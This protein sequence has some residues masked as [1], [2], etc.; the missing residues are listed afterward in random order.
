M[1]RTAGGLAVAL[2]LAGAACAHEGVSTLEAP[3]A[4]S[5]AAEGTVPVDVALEPLQ[6]VVAD[7]PTPAKS[8]AASGETGD[9]H[10][11]TSLGKLEG[12]GV[13][14]EG[15]RVVLA[16]ARMRAA[17]QVTEPALVG[18]ARL[19]PALG[20]GFLFRSSTALYTSDAFDGELRP[21][22]SFPA[23]IASVSFGPRAMLV[24]TLSGERWLVDAKTG[25]PVPMSPPGLVDVAALPDGRAAA[26]TEFGAAQVSGDHGEHWQDVTQR[27]PGPAE[28]LFVHEEAIWLTGGG[29]TARVEPGGGVSLFDK[30][31]QDKPRTL[32]PKDPRWRA[33]EPPIRRAIRLGAPLDDGSVL[34]VSDGDVVRVDPR[35]GAL[36]AVSGGRLPP[37]ATC[38]AVR[39]RDDV[40]VA[41]TRASGPAF[42]ASHL[43]AD[44]APIIE[45]TFV[46]SGTFTAGDDG[47]LAYSAPCSRTRASG[48]SPGRVVCVRGAAGSWEELDLDGVALDAGA[49]GG[50]ATGS[51]SGSG[52][53]P[54]ELR[55]VPRADGGAYGVFFTPKPGA[56]D[57][58]TGEVRMWRAD[59]LPS[60]VRTLDLRSTRFKAKDARGV[61][62]R[63]W[64]AT[65]AGT[66]RGWTD[67]GVVEVGADGAIATSAFSFDRAGLAVAGPFA[68]A[69]GKD[70]RTWQ[71]VDRGAS[72]IEVLAPFVAKPEKI[73]PP[74]VCSPVGCDLGAWYRVGWA[75]TPPSASAPPA[76]AD[77]APLV[78]VPAP[79]R[80][81]CRPVADP[82]ARSVGRTEHSP[83]DLGLGATKLPTSEG[84]SST[85]A[86]THAIEYARFA[87]ARPAVVPARSAETAPD[88]D[89]AAPRA[90]V[91]GYAVDN[92]G[93]RITV[94]GPNRDAM[95]LRR[96]I[97]FVA[98]FDPS[99]AVRR[100]VFGVPEIVASA[101]A[102][103]LGTGDVIAEDP[104]AIS[105]FA[106]V[107]PQD[108]AA[109]SD[110]VFAGA[111]GLVGSARALAGGGARARV[112]MRL[113]ST[114]EVYPV[115]GVSLGGDEIALLLVDTDGQGHVVKWAGGAGVTGVFDVPAP[116]AADL[117][118]A[119]PDALALGAK[120]GELAVVRT[121]SG[122]APP[123]AGDPALVFAPM[124][125]GQAGAQVAVLAP[126]TPST[127]LA[128]GDAACRSDP[129]G[130]RVVVQAARPWI[131]VSG[132]GL[133]HV[134]DAPF[135]ARVRWT[136]SHV[137]LEAIEVRVAD[138]KVLAKEVNMDGAAARVAPVELD[139]ESWVV[140]RFTGTPAAERLAVTPGVESRQALECALLP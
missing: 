121:P 124:A 106:T 82:R 40:V 11:F 97:A 136:A 28:K 135:F 128:E 108:P 100:V 87:F 41:C 118:G 9:V 63:T 131:A 66:L 140:A 77:P 103:G 101:R 31:P 74:R 64:T 86:S 24:R 99:G 83:D 109:P 104:T 92:D 117:A 76:D 7:P 13:I 2:V 56:I 45:Q 129:G 137:C 14:V 68:F 55:W 23:M 52:A 39:A 25:A 90:I 60:G 123:S 91:S 4:T 19:P 29:R 133:R 12:D 75:P 122:G 114:D 15:L 112:G 127:V 46:S 130:F 102:L 93:D 134:E 126:W 78:A 49:A 88:R 1:R 37:D 16:G 48:A 120:P 61:V 21:L 138:V 73:E 125:K 89:E 107:V 65:S 94:N 44:K 72:W 132:P 113:K 84:G 115:S 22:V 116:P 50:G 85:G 111:S 20:G 59:V 110:L 26:L 119:N 57:A 27:L 30:A 32:R 70:G 53:V 105:S 67:S 5:R 62:D 47:A 33:D 79:A 18:A 17:K 139:A 58:R 34:V 6:Y 81:G 43:L 42:V 10:A 3:R 51:A 96:Q 95:A 69:R 35:S 38:E 8:A 71:T 98:P 36:L 80:V 54:S